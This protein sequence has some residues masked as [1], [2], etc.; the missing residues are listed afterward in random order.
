MSSISSSFNISPQLELALSVNVFMHPEMASSTANAASMILDWERG[1]KKGDREN[2]KKQPQTIQML[3]RTG[4][5]ISRDLCVGRNMLDHLRWDFFFFLD[6]LWSWQIR[7][8]TD[9][10]CNY[11]KLPKVPRW[12]WYGANRA[13]D[14]KDTQLTSVC[15]IFLN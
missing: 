10:L 13:W 3:I 2:K 9:D 11:Y 4:W 8:F 1:R 5:I 14:N 6:K 12:F 7:T 15:L